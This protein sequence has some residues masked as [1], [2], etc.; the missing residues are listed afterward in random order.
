M[1]KR[2]RLDEEI[3]TYR[4]T[5][6]DTV[7]I[8]WNGRTVSTLK[9]KDAEKILLKINQASDDKEIQLILAKV[10]GNFKR[11]NERTSKNKNK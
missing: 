8:D 1:D 7:I 11:G 6:N 10:T 4:V 2:N 3:F 5:K 9:G